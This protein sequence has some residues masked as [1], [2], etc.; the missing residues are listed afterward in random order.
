MVPGAPSLQGAGDSLVLERR[1]HVLPIAGDRV[2][3]FVGRL[4]GQPHV[5]ACDRAIL[6]EVGHP[7]ANLTTG[8]VDHHD[9]V[10]H[11]KLLLGWKREIREGKD[12]SHRSGSWGF[13]RG[14]RV[15]LHPVRRAEVAILHK[16]SLALHER[17]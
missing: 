12:G 13:V 3:D 8:E 17:P 6:V 9:E 5:A 14:H 10:I 7:G 1:A 11:A 2:A 16:S 4:R 15:G